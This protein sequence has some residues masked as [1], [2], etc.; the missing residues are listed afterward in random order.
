MPRTVV[1]SGSK[2]SLN[3][4]ETYKLFAAL[5]KAKKGVWVRKLRNEDGSEDFVI[6]KDGNRNRFFGSQR[7][8]Y[9]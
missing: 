4:T 8:S 2:Q 3:K 7:K 5:Q 6:R 9:A 1:K